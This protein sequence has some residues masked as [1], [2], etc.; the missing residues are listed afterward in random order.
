MATAD[1]VLA[2]QFVDCPD[3]SWDTTDASGRALTDAQVVASLRWGAGNPRPRPTLAALQA[4]FAAVDQQDAAAAAQDA[5]AA[6]LAATPDGPL[7]AIE[8]LTARVDELSTRHQ[9][10]A[11]ALAEIKAKVRSTALTSALTYVVSTAAW[12]STGLDTLKARL[13]SIRAGAGG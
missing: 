12:A 1:R 8:A 11:T 7:R 5:A 13:A 2:T 6:K 10:H 3:K 9:A 4:L